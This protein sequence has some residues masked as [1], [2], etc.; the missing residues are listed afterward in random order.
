MVDH[1]Q[2]AANAAE[3]DLDITVERLFRGYRARRPRPAVAL[4][5]P[6]LRACG[7]DAA[8]HRHRRRLGRQRACGAH[9]F[10]CV[11]LA[12]GT[13]RNHE[14]DERVSADALEGML[15]LMIALV[16]EAAAGWRMAV[17]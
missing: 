11:N 12:N 5:E 9:G 14:P 3:C 7:Y 2:D 15:E 1:L 16:D 8:P 4:A 6:A 10:P 17:A 13:E